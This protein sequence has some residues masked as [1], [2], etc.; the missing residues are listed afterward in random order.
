ML[1]SVVI[2]DILLSGH[3]VRSRYHTVSVRGGVSVLFQLSSHR[4]S[5]LAGIS[6]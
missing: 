4:I 5:R 1:I 6:K 3:S 2:N